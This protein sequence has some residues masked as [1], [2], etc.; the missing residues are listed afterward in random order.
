MAKIRFIFHSSKHRDLVDWKMEGI[1]TFRSFGRHRAGSSRCDCSG[2]C[3][4]SRSLVS[5]LVTVSPIRQLGTLH[6]APVS[7]TS[8]RP[9]PRPAPPPPAAGRVAMARHNFQL[10]TFFKLSPS[11]HS[12]WE[13]S[14]VFFN[15]DS[16]V[17]LYIDIHIIERRC[18]ACLLVCKDP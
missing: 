15:F 7:H 8:G 11:P 17:H 12:N 6:S 18:H 13:A 16:N 14:I 5:I 2:H 3:M 10:T 1:H 4:T 9:R